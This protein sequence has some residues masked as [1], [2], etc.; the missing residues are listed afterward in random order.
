MIAL[1]VYNIHGTVEGKKYSDTLIGQEITTIVTTCNI[2]EAIDYLGDRNE[3]KDLVDLD[4][5]DGILYNDGDQMME[6]K[7]PEED[8]IVRVKTR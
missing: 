6:I 5:T 4:A 1:R 3:G 8:I 7:Y 2:D